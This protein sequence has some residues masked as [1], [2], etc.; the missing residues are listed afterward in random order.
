LFKV[1]REVRVVES[2][3]NPAFQVP[4]VALLG[5]VS[6]RQLIQLWLKR[7]DDRSWSNKISGDRARHIRNDRG[8]ALACTEVKS[9]IP[10][11]SP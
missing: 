3:H 11:A 7:H 6:T 9:R 1:K 4:K 5:N 2:A 10:R 8:S